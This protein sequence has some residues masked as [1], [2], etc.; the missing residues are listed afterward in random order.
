MFKCLIFNISA[1]GGF[2][3][4]GAHR[5][6]NHLRDNNWDTE[7]IDFAGMWTVEELKL[8]ALSRIDK[9]TK[10]IGFSHLW[11][12][13][14]ESLEEFCIWVKQNYPYIVIISGSADRPLFVTNQIDYYISGYGENAIIELLSWLFSNGK[15]PRFEIKKCNGGL[16]IQAIQNY[17]AFPLK[18]SMV[19]YEDR[20]FIQSDEWL[21]VEFS[22]G[23]KFKCAFCNF[24]V[25]G[26][27][28]DYSRNSEDFLIQMQDA[29]D[30]FGVK[31]YTVTD[32][33][34]NDSTEKIKKFADAVESL[35]FVPFFTGFIRVDLLVARPQDRI[36]LARMNFLGHFYGVESFNHQAAKAIGKGMHPDKIKQGLID[37]KSYFE[38]NGRKQYRGTI[39]LIVGLPGETEQSLNDTKDWLDGNWQ[40]QNFSSGPLFI[41]SGENV[42]QSLIG[43]D[44]AKYG[45]RP[46]TKKIQGTD[47]INIHD[48][49]GHQLIWENENLDYYRAIDICK[50]F[51]NIKK[52]NFNTDN[53]AL[54]ALGLPSSVSERLKLKDYEPL[55][56]Y[57]TSRRKTLIACYIKKKLNL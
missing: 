21:S 20:D 29:Y 56:D 32:D 2:R 35:S 40:G 18:S 41:P 36:E 54:G 49:Y 6:A 30:R 15:R 57:Y 31:N 23:C 33:T 44:Y 52:N 14:S 25:L 55:N 47:E 11:S 37:I 51:E 12:T 8:L 9:N 22:R 34:F 7:V 24:P 46:M 39:A 48:S 43:N 5:I 53:F 28:E 1:D 4:L 16:L 3:P 10:F 13:W 45:Y 19:K 17:P 50:E 38:N 27:K 42:T 26:V